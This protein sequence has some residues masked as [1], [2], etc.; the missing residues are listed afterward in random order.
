MRLQ[1][2][3]IESPLSM[4][5][6][7]L[8]MHQQNMSMLGMETLSSS[9]LSLTEGCSVGQKVDYEKLLS[10]GVK[11]EGKIALA[12]YGGPFR[13]LKVHIFQFIRACLTYQRSKMLRNMV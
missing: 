4:D 8:V 11:L 10:L 13:G 2:T 7:L 3:L 6:L 1:V 5:I 12:K 9:K